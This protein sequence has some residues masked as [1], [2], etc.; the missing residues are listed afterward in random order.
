MNNAKGFEPLHGV[1]DPYL[2]LVTMEPFYMCNAPPMRNLVDRLMA[3]RG[4]A[5]VPY[6]A[7]HVGEL[8][9]MAPSLNAKVLLDSVEEKSGDP[10]KAEWSFER[11]FAERFP[12]FEKKWHPWLRDLWDD[13]VSPFEGRKPSH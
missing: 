8:E 1:V 13:F 4:V 12:G 2:V 6:Q 7:L 11:Y 5:S 9:Q 10:V 3:E